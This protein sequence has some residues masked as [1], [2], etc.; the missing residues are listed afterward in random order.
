MTN[1]VYE[2]H[3]INHS[4]LPFIY[5]K[6]HI[7]T[8]RNSLPNWH[9]NIEFLYCIGGKGSIRYGSETHDFA[10]GDIV[11]VNADTP[12]YI[13]SAGSVIY[14]CLIIDNSFFTDNG[15]PISTLYF[16]HTIR[17]E[18][19]SA[20]FEN[21][22]SAFDNCDE[23]SICAVADIRYAVLGLIRAICAGYTTDI[24]RELHSAA[25]THV[26]E[27]MVYIRKHISEAITL[28]DIADHVGISKFHLSREFKTFTGKTIVQTVNI[29]RCTE[30]RHLIE[31]GMSVSAAAVS[32]GYNNLS[33]FSRTFT[34]LFGR[35]PSSFLPG[36]TPTH[37]LSHVTEDCC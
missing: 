26:K 17:D 9:E 31:S 33:Y 23:Q 32:C 2:T 22:C 35:L 1:Y 19:I 10:R 7:I 30:A 29:L 6:C 4:L 18:A 15:I 25:N 5:H 14:R 37:K 36:E 11:V 13:C 34:K 16:Q 27:A 21:V 24:P 28:D 8:Q 3:S 12:H 20:L